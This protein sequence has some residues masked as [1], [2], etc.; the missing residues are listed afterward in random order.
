MKRNTGFI[1]ICL[2]LV[3]IA[4]ATTYIVAKDKFTTVSKENEKEKRKEN[5][6]EKRNENIDSSLINKLLDSLIISENGNSK[7]LYFDN[8]VVVTDYNNPDLILFGVKS[9]LKDNNINYLAN[10]TPPGDMSE[11]IY[12]INKD[13]LSNYM[14]NK[15]NNDIKYDLTISKDE[16][17]GY[18]LEN[19]IDLF[20][21]KDK[22]IL[23]N[24]SKSGGRNYIDHKL[25]KYETD[26]NFLSIYTNLVSCISSGAHN[27]CKTTLDSYISENVIL[28]CS[29][30]DEGILETC[31]LKEE[32]VFLESMGKH[33]LNN[34]SSKLK[35]YR[36]TFKKSNNNYYWYSTEVVE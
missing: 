36:I 33:T 4:S 28:D 18:K 35:T 23:A 17:D 32:A 27:V 6:E 12:E 22:W 21:S 7:S 25:I 3:I 16:Y 31:P 24:I 10:I 29:Y 15:F 11:I 2:L 13:N 30:N 8:K 34:L 14:N 19:T 26:E 9:Y 20:S 1:I 5:E